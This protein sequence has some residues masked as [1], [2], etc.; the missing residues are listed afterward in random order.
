M[1]CSFMAQWILQSVWALYTQARYGCALHDVG[2]SLMVVG[3]ATAVVQGFVVRA[4]VPRIGEQRALG[5]GLA[6]AGASHAAIGFA[7]TGALL[8]LCIFPLALGGLAGPSVQA[9]IS[10]EVGASEQGEMQGA[11]NSLGGIAAIIGPILGTALL[12]RFAGADS[13]PPLHPALL[14][15]PFFAGAAFN[16][17]GLLLALR[18]IRRPTTP[19][20]GGADAKATDAQNQPESSASR[21]SG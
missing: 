12:A 7:S 9:I 15:A 6:L 2:L 8:L 3:V 18:V 17:L 14:G 4:V 13:S 10:R 5:L 11:L 16:A 19:G 1:M 20:A 21:I